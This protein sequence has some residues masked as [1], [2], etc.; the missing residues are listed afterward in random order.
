MVGYFSWNTRIAA[1]FRAW[2]H[3]KTEAPRGNARAGHDL[4]LA[5]VRQKLPLALPCLILRPPW[6]AD[7]YAAHC[8]QHVRCALIISVARTSLLPSSNIGTERPRNRG[9]CCI[10][11]KSKWCH[12]TIQKNSS[13]G[14]ERSAEKLTSFLRLRQ[15]NR[16][17]TFI[18]VRCI[19]TEVAQRPA[20]SI[21]YFIRWSQRLQ[22]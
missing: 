7:L 10:E 8:N 3:D 21:M 19:K 4:R 14:I 15:K 17:V 12:Q 1:P 18:K 6:V 22:R 16:H 5:T 11:E 9:R 13:V 2:A 20:T